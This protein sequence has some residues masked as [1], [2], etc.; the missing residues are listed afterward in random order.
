MLNLIRKDLLLHKTGFPLWATVF[1]VVLAFQAWRGFSPS[2]YLMLACAYGTIFP[3]VLVTLEDKSRSGPFNCSLPVTRRQIVRAKYVIS[4][5][6]AV[7]LTLIGLVLYAVIA[8]ESLLTIW[9]MAMVGQALVTL[10]LG[11]G[12]TL[13]VLLRFGFWGFTGAFAAMMSL[14][15]LSILVLQALLPDLHLMDSFIAI[16]DFVARTRTQL[17]A[18]L[19]LVAIVVA[20][21]ALNVVSCEIAVMLFK[22]REF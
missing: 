2:F 7:L 15:M 22:R 8:A 11:L 19:F 3:A 18:P 10:S 12:M 6:L 17:G 14:C 4:W 9:T 20:G 1:V 21:G 13:P 5:A 16:S